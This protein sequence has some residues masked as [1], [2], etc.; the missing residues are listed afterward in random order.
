VAVTWILFAF[1]CGSCGFETNGLDEE[2]KIVGD[3]LVKAV[4]WR[5]PLGFEASVWFD[6]AEKGCRERRI[7]P[8]EELE[9]DKAD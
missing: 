7:N 4:E 5:S 6:R 2:I 1:K 9:K 8:F 3:A